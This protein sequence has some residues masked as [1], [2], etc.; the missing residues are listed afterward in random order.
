MTPAPPSATIGA[1]GRHKLY[2]HAEMLEKENE[3]LNQ[4]LVKMQLEIE[5][6]SSAERSFNS[7]SILTLENLAS[8]PSPFLQ[9]D[10]NDLRDDNASLN[11]ELMST[12]R[13]LFKAKEQIKKVAAG[14]VDREKV[15]L[16]QENLE[17]IQKKKE[18]LEN[19]IALL[20]SDL[21]DAYARIERME[22]E[23]KRHRN[24]ALQ[25]KHKSE[26]DRLRV[27]QY[28]QRLKHERENV[29][30]GKKAA[31]S[32][33]SELKQLSSM[34][35]K[36]YKELKELQIHED[37][38]R[39]E[40]DK[41]RHVSHVLAQKLQLSAQETH[42]LLDENERLRNLTSNIS[43]DNALIDDTPHLPNVTHNLSYTQTIDIA[44]L[45][46]P[47]KS[48]APN[49]TFI[50][51]N[52]DDKIATKSPSSAFKKSLAVQIHSALKDNNDS[53]N[54]SLS[55]F[56][57][58]DGSMHLFR[59]SSGRLFGRDSPERDRGVASHGN[60]IVSN[61]VSIVD[62]TDGITKS[63]IQGGNDQDV[64]SKATLAEGIVHMESS[65]S[66][67][68]RTTIKVKNEDTAGKYR[69]WK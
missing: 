46:S 24:I 36:V 49:S 55:S 34:Y 59:D 29:S 22:A 21:K 32:L 5:R 38:L 35:N 19:Q 1:G 69:S 13:K 52:V 58:N 17:A 51:N 23:T 39:Q 45:Q 67:D 54:E 27:R 50:A 61:D 68:V 42:R 31:E 3:T 63:T 57:T 48:N 9:Q 25:S 47:V 33:A 30:I 18:E 40:I 44:D 8:N 15:L 16:L 7:Q 2:Q 64:A 6:L 66:G 60:P 65:E 43:S 14:T 62:D 10:L 11:A 41:E 37:S 28:E 4:Q 26:T 12:Q 56:A 53:M 20:Q